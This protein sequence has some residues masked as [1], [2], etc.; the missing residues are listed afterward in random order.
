M[1]Y[2]NESLEKLRVSAHSNY[3]SVKKMI[4]KLGKLNSQK[5][6]DLSRMR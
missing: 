3:K 2:T 1:N 6:D 4:S 5:L